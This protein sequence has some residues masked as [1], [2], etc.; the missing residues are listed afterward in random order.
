MSTLPIDQM[1]QEQE[2]EELLKL[3]EG[4]F[5]RA[6][7]KVHSRDYAAVRALDAAMNVIA[8]DV[9]RLQEYKG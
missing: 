8:E 1:T 4:L 3:R 2:I 9:C 6:V 7:M 5:Q